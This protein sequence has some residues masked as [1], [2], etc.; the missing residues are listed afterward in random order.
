MMTI[1]II[2]NLWASHMMM[3]LDADMTIDDICQLYH[4][5]LAKKQI[6]LSLPSSPSK[7]ITNSIVIK[8]FINHQLEGLEPN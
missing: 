6:V 1:P 3:M 2:W 4:S 7:F 5:S 8:L